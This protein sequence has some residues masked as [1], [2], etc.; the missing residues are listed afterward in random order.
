MDEFDLAYQC[1]LNAA[2]L[3]PEA[4]KISGPA[5]EDLLV[6]CSINPKSKHLI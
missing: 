2:E 6:V 5:I 4:K 3:D 1:Y